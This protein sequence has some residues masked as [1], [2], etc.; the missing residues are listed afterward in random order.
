[1]KKHRLLLALSA[2]SVIQCAVADPAYMDDVRFFSHFHRD[3]AHSAN[4]Y[5]EGTFGFADFDRFDTTS[6]GVQGGIPLN[7]NMEI[8]L[9]GGFANVDHDV[10]SSESGMM[11]IDVIGKF[12]LKNLRGHQVTVGASLSLPVGDEDIGQDRTDIGF[13]GAVRRPITKNMVVMGS[14][15]LDFFDLEPDRETS[16]HLG[17]GLIFKSDKQLHFSGEFALDTEGDVFDITGGLD[18]KTLASGRLRGSISLGLDD[19]SPDFA[20]QFGYLHQF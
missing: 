18:F 1:M 7:P 8:G 12:H 11:D 6:I 4:G 17:G 19:G 10:G 2:I 16:L 14:V 15:G 13:F 5:I 3:S 9:T 20:L